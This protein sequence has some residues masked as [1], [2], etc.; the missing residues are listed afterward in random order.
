MESYILQNHGSNNLLLCLFDFLKRVH[1][2][3]LKLLNCCYNLTTNT[4]CGI[5]PADIKRNV[6]WKTI[7]HS[8][9]GW[10][11]NVFP[12]RESFCFILFYYLSCQAFSPS[13]EDREKHFSVS[14]PLSY[15]IHYVKLILSVIIIIIVI[16]LEAYTH[17]SSSFVVFKQNECE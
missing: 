14:Y 1:L 4:F 8:H 9:S 17:M 15:C 7:H 13:L 2:E 5:Y 3:Y 12:R 11:E 6:S 16:L 10:I